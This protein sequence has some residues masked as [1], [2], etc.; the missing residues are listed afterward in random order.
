MYLISLDK[1]YFLRIKARLSCNKEEKKIWKFFHVG[2][3]TRLPS[4]RSH[5]VMAA[6]RRPSITR[7]TD[8]FTKRV[9]R[10]RPSS[11]ARRPFCTSTTSPITNSPAS[12]TII[13]SIPANHQLDDGLMNVNRKLFLQ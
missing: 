13:A 1:I 2:G 7:R 4:R 11:R 9:S 8:H 6:S 10:C 3:N 12:C 5:W